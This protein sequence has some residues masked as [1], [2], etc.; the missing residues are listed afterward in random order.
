MRG[1]HR[2][3]HVAMHQVVQ[4]DAELHVERLVEPQFGAHA[5]DHVGW[6]VIADDGD[7]RIYRHRTAD[8]KGD[9]DQT[10]QRYRHAGD[11]RQQ[12]VD[13][14]RE[15][16]T[17]GWLGGRAHALVIARVAG[18]VRQ[19]PKL[20]CRT[21]PCAWWRSRRSAARSTSAS[22]PSNHAASWRTSPYASCC[23]VPSKRRQPVCSALRRGNGSARPAASPCELSESSML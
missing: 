2:G 17:R 5:G 15:S 7:H 21:R 22:A 16:P 11:A 3:A 19:Q 8:E 18:V 1:H 12:R 13:T 6:R 20:R 10:E 9:Q 4:I 23:R 14:C